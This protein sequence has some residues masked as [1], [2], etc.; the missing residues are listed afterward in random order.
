MSTEQSGLKSG[1]TAQVLPILLLE[2]HFFAA[3]ALL[4]FDLNP[5]EILSI[6]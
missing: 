1:R 2:S 3:T 6:T 5:T 4:L